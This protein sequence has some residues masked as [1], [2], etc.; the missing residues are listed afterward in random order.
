MM[1]RI[2]SRIAGWPHRAIDWLCS[3]RADYVAFRSRKTTPAHRARRTLCL[4]V[5]GL[6]AILMLFCSSAG[7]VL[8]LMLIA[9]FMSFSL[10]EDMP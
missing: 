6:A 9:T 8:V 4:L 10:L 7:C 5:W 3:G 2:I 1:T